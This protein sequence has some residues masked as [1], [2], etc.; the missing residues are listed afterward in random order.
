M[1][2]RGI[3]IRARI[4]VVW[5]VWLT[6]ITATNGHAACVGTSEAVIKGRFVRC[7]DAKFYLEAS[8]AYDIYERALQDIRANTDPQILE[9]RLE[10]LGVQPGATSLLPEDYEARVAVVMIDWRVSIAPW[11]AGTSD[12]VETMAP[13]QALNETVRYWWNGSIEQCEGIQAGSAIQLWVHPPCCDTIPGSPV[14]LVTM[15]YAEE[16]PDKLSDGLAAALVNR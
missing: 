6:V 7:E 12:T 13:P 15:L 3:V 4:C 1:V 14:C 10:R 8:G 16:T 5:T 11:L 2:K 9:T